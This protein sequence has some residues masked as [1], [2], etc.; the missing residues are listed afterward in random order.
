M[1]V[2]LSSVAC[3][4]A[5]SASP[6]HASLRF[7]SSIMCISINADKESE[8]NLSRFCDS[9]I[10]SLHHHLYPARIQASAAPHPYALASSP[11]RVRLRP[12]PTA[13]ACVLAPP[14]T[15]VLTTRSFKRP[16]FC[17]CCL[18]L[19]RVLLCSKTSGGC[20]SYCHVTS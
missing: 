18:Q 13:Y 16:P 4:S 7:A 17:R 5:S 11:H 8:I 2:V 19:T 15:L 12:R 3:G 20:I 10:K 1:A 9:A 14:R 6:P